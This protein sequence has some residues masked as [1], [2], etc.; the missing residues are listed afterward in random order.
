MY[1]LC[2]LVEDIVDE[3]ILVVVEKCLEMRGRLY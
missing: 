2:R 1:Y 3:D